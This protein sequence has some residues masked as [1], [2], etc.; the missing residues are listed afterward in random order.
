MAGDEMGS[1][2]SSLIKIIEAVNTAGGISVHLSANSTCDEHRCDWWWWHKYTLIQLPT[3]EFRGNRTENRVFFRRLQW[4]CD[5]C[6]HQKKMPQRQP[7]EGKSSDQKKSF[8]IIWWLKLHQV[9]FHGC[10][11][12]MNDDS[13]LS[14][15][16]SMLH[17]VVNLSF[18][19]RREEMSCQEV[20][21]NEWDD[22]LHVRF[23][24]TL[25]RENFFIFL[26]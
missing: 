14:E 10:W 24:V 26:R 19:P 25:V 13:Q 17:I 8:T 9:C 20:G 21:M 12:T 16:L 4:M 11:L 6:H 18:I 2:L 22:I 3:F 5:W 15:Q 23:R 1:T 7:R